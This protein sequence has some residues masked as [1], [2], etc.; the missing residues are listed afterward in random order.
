[1]NKSLLTAGLLLAMCLFHNA[2]AADVSITTSLNT[3]RGD[4]A[5]LA[6]Y[7][8]D[9][10]GKYNRTLW[11]AGSKSKYYKHLLDWSRGGGNKAAEYDGVTGASVLSGDSLT[12]HAVIDDALIDAGYLIRVDSAVEDQ[13]EHR[14][15][16]EIALTRQ[17]AGNSVQGRGY[18]KTLSYSL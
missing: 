9:A 4:G 1:M 16:A 2:Q 10:S 17:G 12:V 7:L 14:I 13:R 11:V 5:Y 3:F 6:I 18:V 8:T 15:D